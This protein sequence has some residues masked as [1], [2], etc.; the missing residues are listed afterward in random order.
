M[1]FLTSQ[2]IVFGIADAGSRETQFRS[3]TTCRPVPN[4]ANFR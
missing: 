2:C 1:L 3:A 4:M